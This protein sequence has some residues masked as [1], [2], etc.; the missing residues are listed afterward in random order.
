MTAEKIWAKETLTAPQQTSIKTA[1]L[2]A[3]FG[4]LLMVLT[5]PVAELYVFPKLIVPGDPAQ[6]V[7]HLQAERGFFVLGILGYL[8]TFIADIVVAWALYIFFKPAN[9]SLSLLT[10]LFRLVYTVIALIAI[11]NLTT[12]YK[13][14]N[15]S[16]YT[17][18]LSVDQAN[19]QVMLN[20]YSF[21]SI[22][23]FGIL[24]FGIHLGLLGYLSLESKYVPNVFGILLIIS[25]LGYL[26]TTLQPYLMPEKRIDFA[27][28]TFYGELFFMFWLLIKAW[29]LC[30]R[31]L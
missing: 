1:A 10:A 22:W 3:G 30:P 6:T 24:F 11:A 5:A 28:Y 7:H 27:K 26:A 4:L 29:R 16:T 19:N 25:S 14:I 13:I 23:Y 12:I 8:V 9:Q 18:F 17:S 20:Y 2:V 15:T 21:K 31:N